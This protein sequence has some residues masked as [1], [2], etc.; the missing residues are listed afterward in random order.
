MTYNIRFA[1]APD[2][3]NSWPN[4]K[5]ALLDLV[6]R[7]DPDV[8]GVQEALASQ[9]EEIAAA[10]P[11]H[12]VLGVGRD[13]GLRKGEFSAVFTRRSRLGLREGGTRWV[14]ETPDRPGSLGPGARIPRV[15]VW[16]EFFTDSGRR[17]LVMNAH[18]DH[19]S[20]DARLLGGRAMR[21]WADARPGR[22][23]LVLG[24]FNC[25]PDA[26]PVQV[27]TQGDRFTVATPPSGPLGTFNGFD[28]TRTGG[29]MIDL[30]LHCSGWSLVEAKI[31]RTLTP[32]GRPPSDHFPVVA[33]LRLD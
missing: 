8:L 30:V 17:V 24:D 11:G 9:V 14:S 13:D 19:Q 31:D 7:H 1:T 27:L 33:R 6:R 32:E 25:P 20:A 10:L 3:E 22:P 4:R 16:G 26:P 28:P 5:E 2:G 21:A 12:D 29:D 23:A 18:L 15:F